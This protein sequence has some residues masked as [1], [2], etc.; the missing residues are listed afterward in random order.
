[1]SDPLISRFEDLRQHSLTQIQAPGAASARRTVHRRATVKAAGIAA[2]VMAA[3]TT[4]VV[5]QHGNNNGMAATPSPS[6]YPSP[7]ASAGPWQGLPNK[8]EIAAG[9]VPGA[10]TEVATGAGYD[11]GFNVDKGQF[12]VRVGCSGPAPLPITIRLNNRINQ[13]HTIPC[14]DA[15]VMVEY[16]ITMRKAGDVNVFVGGSKGEGK[17]DAYALELY[18]PGR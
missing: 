16:K 17:Y 10:D 7:S 9:L 1:M 8:T 18:G 4:F 12:R 11:H 6:G 14:T 3:G 15:G 2:V 5:A 13:Q